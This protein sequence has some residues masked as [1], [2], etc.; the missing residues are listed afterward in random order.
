MIDVLLINSPMVLNRR[1]SSYFVSEGDEKSNY[2]M[3]ILYIAAYLRKHEVR[4]QVMDITAAGYTLEDILERVA[5]E[6]PVLVGISAMT[7]GL[8]SAVVIAE[9]LKRKFGDSVT[10]GLGGSHVNSDLKFTERFPVF[11]FSVLGEGEKTT[12]DIVR[13]LQAGEKVR[14]IIQGVPIDDLE[15]IPPPARDLINYKD[16]FRD[17]ESAKGRKPAATMLSS[18]GCPFHCSFCSIPVIRHKVRIRDAKSVVD[19]MEAIYDTCDG[20]YSFVDDVLTLNKTSMIALCREILDRKLKVRWMGMTRANLLSEEMVAFMARAGCTDL[21]FGVESG[22]E[23]VRNEVIQK[24]VTDKEIADSVALCRKHG[25]HVSLFLMAGFPGETWEDLKATINIGS[26][27]KADLI[28]IRITVPFPGTDVFDYA[29]KENIIPATITDDYASGK[30][31]ARSASF[32]DVWPLFVPKGLTMED[33]VRAKK[34]TYYRFYLDPT[35]MFR[36]VKL[37]FRDHERFREDLKLFKVAPY[38]LVKGKTK[39]SMS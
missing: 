9:E 15:E 11:D 12:L 38:A 35:W 25:I 31:T 22:S 33:L 17:E 2:P 5:S 37:W 10:V 3:G 23:R 6:K 7:P 26:K 39:G 1:G 20:A 13:R 30:L 27:V 8:R 36:R 19:E 34:R 14:G 21:F 24:R 32:K 29:V 16:Y 18:R 4:V 28:G